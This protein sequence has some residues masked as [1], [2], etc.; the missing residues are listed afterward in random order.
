M[1]NTNAIL[2]L[3]SKLSTGKITELEFTKGLKELSETT[4]NVYNS[5]IQEYAQIIRDYAKTHPQFDY[6]ALES[7]ISNALS[8]PGST[9]AMIEFV[10]NMYER[11]INLGDLS[12]IES[13][14]SNASFVPEVLTLGAVGA[15]VTQEKIDEMNQPKVDSKKLQDLKELRQYLIDHNIELDEKDIEQLITR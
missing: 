14:I 2:D 11:S 5:T 13:L 1:D 15:K 8:N 9:D 10:T 4:Q 3:Q 7:A 12:S 6:T